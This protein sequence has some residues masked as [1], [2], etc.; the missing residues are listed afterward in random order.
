MSAIVS[1]LPARADLA[2]AVVRTAGL[3]LMWAALWGDVS[4]ATFVA[5]GIVAVG[6][7][8]AFPTLAPRPSGR[9]NVLALARL[10]LVFAWMLITANLSVLRRVMSPRLAITPLVVDVALPPCSDAVATVV[11]NAVTL[12]P[13]TLTLDVAR[14]PDAV[15]LTVHNLDANDPARVRADVLAL[16]ALAAAAFPAGAHIPVEEGTR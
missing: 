7:Q 13:G 1:R 9:V 12:T 16:Y 4:L 11:A 6:A 2:G 5:G 8:L 15:T 3:A 14:A 10:G